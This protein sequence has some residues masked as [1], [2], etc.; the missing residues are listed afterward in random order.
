MVTS[1]RT[2]TAI[3]SVF[4]IAFLI[5]CLFAV[6]TYA[7]NWTITQQKHITGGDKTYETHYSGAGKFNAAW[8]GET[9]A[10]VYHEHLPKGLILVFADTN[11]E[12]IGEPIQLSDGYSGDV[13]WDGENFVIFATKN[14]ILTLFKYT[15]QGELVDSKEYS[16]IETSDYPFIKADY[17]NGAYQVIAQTTSG[18]ATLYTLNQQGDLNPGSQ[19]LSISV[20]LSASAVFLDDSIAIL[21]SQDGSTAN[22]TALLKVFDYQGNQLLSETFSGFSITPNPSLAWNG[23]TL[24]LVLPT[25]LENGGVELTGYSYDLNGDE[26]FPAQRVGY[27]PPESYKYTINL[28]TNLIWA[29]DQFV[30]EY[31]YNEPETAKDENLYVRSI[32]SQGAPLSDPIQITAEPLDQLDHALVW[33]GDK[34]NV[35]TIEKGNHNAS[36]DFTELQYVDAGP[37]ATPT[38]TPVPPTPTPTA[39]PT[40]PPQT[41]A[42]TVKAYIDGSDILNFQGGNVW[43]DHLEYSKPSHSTTLNGVEWHP[44]WHTSGTFPDDREYSDPF[45]AL[46]PSLPQEDGFYYQILS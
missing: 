12:L 27:I 3:A 31:D 39:I 41:E 24:L 18:G 13:L 36:L 28:T 6:N 15:A 42:V 7:G 32:D 2:N 26:V 25:R 8:S 11:G 17:V 34:L 20:G 35:F 14:N 1:K 22:K 4:N 30:L 45:T 9:S 29:G 5:V 44:K 10:I 46:S 43:Y 16:T 21:A 37:Y 23:N 33:A 19:Y 40:L 38:F